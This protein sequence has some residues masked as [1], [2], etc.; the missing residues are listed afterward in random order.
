M[1]KTD[2]YS[3]PQW[4]KQDF[5]KMEDFNDAFGKTDAALKANADATATG[6]NAEI[7]ARGEAVAA[8]AENR[9]AADAAL[10]ASL[11]AAIGSGGK[12]CRI[13]TGSYT[14]TGTSGSDAPVELVSGFKPML[15]MLVHGDL[16]FFRTRRG[17]GKYKEQEFTGT[18]GSRFYI[19]WEDTKVSWYSTATPSAAGSEG[20][21]NTT[22]ETYYYLLLGFSENAEG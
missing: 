5:I 18:G 21:A 12:T 19:T 13:F 11:A 3:L 9:S 20:Q 10:Q 17:E 2:N 16:S 15:L 4:E 8:E 14:G 1:K 6:L 22:G 7:A